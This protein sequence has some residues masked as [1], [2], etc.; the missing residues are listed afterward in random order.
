[1][2]IATTGFSVDLPYHLIQSVRLAQ[3]L[4]ESSYRVHIPAQHADKFSRLREVFGVDFT[5]GSG[6][7]PKL[8]G[9]HVSHREPRTSIGSIE[10]PLIF[11][12]HIARRCR[13]LWAGDRTVGCSFAGLITDQRRAVLERWVRDRF[14][15]RRTR[16]ADPT[17]LDRVRSSTRRRL[18]IKPRRARAQ[19]TDL[20]MWSSERGREF[21]GKSWDEE[22]QALLARS[23]FVLCPC[24]DHVWSYRFFEAALCGAIPVV[25]RTC[26]AYQGFQFRTM[27]D[28]LDGLRWSLDEARHNF[29]L[30]RERLT[31]PRAELDAEIALLLGSR[32]NEE[33][34]AAV[35]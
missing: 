34:A 24:G 30:C 15:G 23:R 26:A 2:P 19:P 3:A 21:P 28:P 25:E 20:V 27:D 1:M 29:A 7:V 6:S 31:V 32:R 35:T 13:D 17:L 12:H 5:V 10:R 22:Y 8:N 16:L 4:M 18:G 14:P 9:V 33:A 11:P